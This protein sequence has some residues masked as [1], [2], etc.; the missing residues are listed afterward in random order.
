[1]IGELIPSTHTRV[2]LTVA[3][4]IAAERLERV[5]LVGSRELAEAEED[6]SGLGGHAISIAHPVETTLR[7][8]R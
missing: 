5:D 6:H 8:C 1:M 3:T 7:R 4:L 2:R